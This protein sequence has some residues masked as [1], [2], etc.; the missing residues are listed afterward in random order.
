MWNADP[1]TFV[2]LLSL[3]QAAGIVSAAFARWGAESRT[4]GFYYGI[5]YGLLALAGVA[6]VMSLAVSA[7]FWLLSSVLLALMVLTAT[8]DLGGSRRAT[9]S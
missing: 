7:T 2:I 9:V 6:N 8:L 5:F 3:V 4:P 1:Q